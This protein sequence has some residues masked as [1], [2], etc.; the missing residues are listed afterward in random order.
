MTENEKIAVMNQ[1]IFNSFPCNDLFTPLE[2][3]DKLK[4]IKNKL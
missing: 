1:F 3:R 4:E 2:L